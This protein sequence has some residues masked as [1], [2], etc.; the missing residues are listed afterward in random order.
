MYIGKKNRSYTV[1][2]KVEAVKWHQMNGENCSLTARTSGVDRK[3]I[4]EWE[5]PTYDKLLPL[6]CGKTKKKSKLHEGWTSVDKIS[7]GRM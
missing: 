4:R 7:Q 6:C 2:F 1:E 5:K 3:R